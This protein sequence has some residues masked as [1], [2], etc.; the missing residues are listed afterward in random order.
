MP[1]AGFYPRVQPA[2]NLKRNKRKIEHKEL[3]SCSIFCLI[4]AYTQQLEILVT[5]PVKSK[6]KS[7][8][9]TSGIAKQASN[10]YSCPCT[11]YWYLPEDDTSTS[12]LY[13]VPVIQIIC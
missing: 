9:R 11:V 1:G 2:A 12:T 5:D 6:I 8:F 4:F 13:T 3:S 7:I 10:G